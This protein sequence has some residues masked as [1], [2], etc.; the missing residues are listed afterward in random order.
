MQQRKL[1]YYVA[2]SIDHY[3][4]HSDESMDGFLTEGQHIADYLNSLRDFDTVLMGRK[5]YEWGFQ[6]GN[7]PGQ[8]APVYGHMMQY[9][10]S[11]TMELY[12]HEQLRVVRDDPAQ[13]VQKLKQADGTSIYLSGG[14][15]LAGYLLQHG[16]VDDIILKV[17]PVIF[18]NGVPVF[19]DLHQTINLNMVNA[20]VYPNGMIFQ[21]YT[22]D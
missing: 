5:T 8:P 13:F 6:F 7:V 18:G 15:Q 2:T 9:V 17:N 12:E 14:G 3:I 11:Q 21:H 10:F 22:V 20:T 4:A 19:G 16:L 1:V